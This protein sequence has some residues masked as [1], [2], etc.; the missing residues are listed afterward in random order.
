MVVAFWMAAALGFGGALGIGLPSRSGGS[1]PAP[2]VEVAIHAADLGRARVEVDSPADQPIVP[3]SRLL[4]ADGLQPLTMLVWNGHAAGRAVFRGRPPADMPARPAQ[5]RAWWIRPDALGSLLEQWPVGGELLAPLDSVGPAARSAW[6]RAGANHGMRHGDS[7]WARQHGQPVARLDVRLVEPDLCF[8]A[9]V[10]LVSELRLTPGE[11]VALWPGPGRRLRGQARSAVALVQ[12]QENDQ[13]VWV[14]APR[15]VACP[16]EPRVDFYRAGRLLASGV[17]ERRDERFWYVRALRT[18]GGE[19]LRVGDAAVIRTRADIARRRFAAR[20]FEVTTEGFLINAG[21]LDGL[22]TGDTG[23]ASRDGQ[24]LGSA[25]IQKVQRSYAIVRPRGSPPGAELRVGDQLRFAPPPEPG[26]TVAMIEHA[27]AET[28]FTARL[29]LPTSPPLLRPLAVRAAGETIGVAVLV[30]AR[31]EQSL[32]FVFA[33]SLTG[34]LVSGAEL[35]LEP[36]AGP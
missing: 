35:V 16:P 3:G 4:V 12:P 20:I 28:L 1:P 14:A 32:G 29:V 21:E 30:A 23:V 36:A 31:G 27:T 22:A 18:A 33:E 6:V 9:V 17:A 10:P 15:N 25:V 7:W 2:V 5:P 26:K 11:K 19:V 34:P 13:I 8:C 24:T